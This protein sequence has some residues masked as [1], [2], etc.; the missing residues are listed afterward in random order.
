M[1]NP[2]Q[3]PNYRSERQVPVENVE[4]A[5]GKPVE[6]VRKNFSN[7]KNYKNWLMANG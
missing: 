2:Q 1:K 6:C 7:D 3:N 5:C 4:K